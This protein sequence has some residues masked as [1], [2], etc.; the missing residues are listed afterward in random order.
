[1]ATA[2]GAASASLRSIKSGLGPFKV[3]LL[4]LAC[5]FFNVLLMRVGVLYAYRVTC[6][7]VAGGIDGAIVA[8]ALAFTFGAKLR[9]GTTGLLGGYGAHEVSS[10][11]DQAS[12]YAE[13]LHTHSEKLLVA[14]LG[15]EGPLHDDVQLEIYWIACTAAFVIMS[16]MFV[17]LVWS[18][19]NETGDRNESPSKPEP[20]PQ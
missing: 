20:L 4:V 16:V 12:K 15:P 19:R 11:F 2:V 14:L 5:L 3:P 13:W 7:M 17:E 6:G 18:A 8:A 9:A 10:G 1:M